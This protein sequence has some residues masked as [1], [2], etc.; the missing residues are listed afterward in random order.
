MSI[1]KAIFSRR[2]AGVPTPIKYLGLSKGKISQT[3]SVI[4]YIS[5]CGS[6]TDKPPIAFPKQF[7]DA[8]N[9]ADSFLKSVYVLP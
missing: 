2:L 1:P 5:S 4:S 8:T 7:F 6:P 9:S 3:V